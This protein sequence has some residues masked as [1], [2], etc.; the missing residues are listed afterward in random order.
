MDI[1][2]IAKLIVSKGVPDFDSSMFSEE[3]RVAIFGQA[4]ELFFRQGKFEQ[5]II[6]LEKAGLPLPV[7]KI[8]EVADRKMLLGEYDQ[9][10]VLLAKIG[11]KHMSEF[12]KANFLSK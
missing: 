11:D 3:Q 4:S 12:I 7:D 1:H 5:G 9:A 10:Y 8:K 2:P 6:C